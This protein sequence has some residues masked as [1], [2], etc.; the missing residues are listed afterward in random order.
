LGNA[1]GQKGQWDEAIACWREAIELNPKYVAVAGALRAKAERM[2]AIRVKQRE[3]TIPEPA[4]ARPREALERLMQ[5]YE[6]MDRKDEAAKCRTELNTI[7]AARKKPEK[8]P[9][10]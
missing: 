3:P 1:L 4:K 6:A 5:L 7:M 2:A 8:Q 9:Q 10:P